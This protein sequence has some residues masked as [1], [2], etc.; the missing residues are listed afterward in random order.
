M[1]SHPTPVRVCHGY[2]PS[3]NSHVYYCLI[4]LSIRFYLWEDSA[5]DLRRE[6]QE[7]YL[8]ALAREDLYMYIYKRLHL[9]HTRQLYPNVG[10]RFTRSVAQRRRS[11]VLDIQNPDMHTHIIAS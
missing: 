8:I 9:L 7:M 6:N 1:S 4:G 10:V 2:Q 3:K 5:S 11:S